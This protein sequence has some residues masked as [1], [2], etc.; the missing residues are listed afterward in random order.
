MRSDDHGYGPNV[1]LV[2]DAWAASAVARIS[3]PG[4]AD[5]V[6]HALLTRCFQ[7]LLYAAADHLPTR[8][9]R[10]PTRMTEHHPDVRLEARILAPQ[11]VVIVDLARAGMLP[12]HIL[13]AELLLLLDPLSI[14]VDHVYMQRTSGA[15]GRV[16]GVATTGSKVGGSIEGATVL[17]PD[18]MGATGSSVSAALSMYKRMYGTPARIFTLHL[19]V[20]PEYLARLREDHPE[21]EVFALRLDRG[22]SPPDVLAS[23][24]GTRWAE[25]R[26]LDPRDYIVPG[27]GGLGE[28]INNCG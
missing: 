12:A 4:P 27:A 14:R 5:V 23:P 1:H 28:L 22:F 16:D 15:D 19:I 26:G 11:P 9:V 13:Q 2:R 7:R 10:V 21:V 25:E 24:P 17:L 3:A 18:P 8:E 6:F 20:T